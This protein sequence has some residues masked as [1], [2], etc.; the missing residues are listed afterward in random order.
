MGQV[1]M[2]I[3]V[4][5]LHFRVSAL[6]ET[7]YLAVCKLNESKTDIVLSCFLAHGP[8]VKE[9]CFEKLSNFLG[10]PMSYILLLTSSAPIFE[11]KVH[12]H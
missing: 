4:H 6:K 8:I 9:P 2:H 10:A 12:V 5:T 1:L 11:K 3:H 7:S